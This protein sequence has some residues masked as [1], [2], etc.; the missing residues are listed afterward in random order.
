MSRFHCAESVT[1]A[2]VGMRSCTLLLFPSSRRVNGHRLN[3]FLQEG[4][5]GRESEACGSLTERE[6]TNSLFPCSIFLIFLGKLSPTL[7]HVLTLIWSE[8]SQAVGEE[9]SVPRSLVGYREVRVFSHELRHTHCFPAAAGIQTAE[10]TRLIL[11]FSFCAS[12]SSCCLK[13]RRLSGQTHSL[14]CSSIKWVE[15]IWTH[16]DSSVFCGDICRM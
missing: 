8:V 6:K 12:C 13:V 1:Y 9:A 10:D 4:G 5:G 15:T 2:G 14:T 11:S 3:T 16:F 7:L